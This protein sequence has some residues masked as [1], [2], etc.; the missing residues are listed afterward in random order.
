MS[1]VWNNQRT[2]YLRNTNNGASQVE[3]VFAE[4]CGDREQQASAAYCYRLG[5]SL[6]DI[7]AAAQRDKFGVL[8]QFTET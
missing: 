8:W 4:A 5:E 2:R 3:N 7:H 1:P 6:V